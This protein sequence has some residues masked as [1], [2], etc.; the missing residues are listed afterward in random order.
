MDSS[1]DG[2]DSGAYSEDD[3]VSN[4]TSAPS[5]QGD[6]AASDVTSDDSDEAA[7]AGEA[8]APGEIA[9]GAAKTAVGGRGANKTPRKGQTPTGNGAASPA[10]TPQK[11]S[12]LC[13]Q[14][15]SRRLAALRRSFPDHIRLAVVPGSTANKQR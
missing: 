9:N 2:G 15:K 5:S 4:D 6:D 3:D 13:S 11:V 1:E 12:Y 10:A 8:D 7:S 14:L